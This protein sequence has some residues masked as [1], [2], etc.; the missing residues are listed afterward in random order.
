SRNWRGPETSREISRCDIEEYRFS[1]NRSSDIASAARAILAQIEWQRFWPGNE[2]GIHARGFG[3]GGLLFASIYG[4]WPTR[5][6]FWRRGVC[7]V[8]KNRRT[9]ESRGSRRGRNAETREQRF[10]CVENWFCE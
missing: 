4:C 10:S 5:L 2:S 3:G 7:L 1:R 8:R 9:I 6:P